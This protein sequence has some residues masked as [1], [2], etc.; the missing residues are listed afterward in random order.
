MT[1]HLVIYEVLCVISWP[2]AMQKKKKKEEEEEEEE[3][4]FTNATENL[5][6]AALR[7]E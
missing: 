1:R 7:P 4:E 2:I 3:E 5:T 6:R